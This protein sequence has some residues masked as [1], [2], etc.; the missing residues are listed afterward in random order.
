MTAVEDLI[1]KQSH[2]RTEEAVT[3]EKD[4]QQ[5]E[6]APLS[7]QVQQEINAM[8][9]CRQAKMGLRSISGLHFAIVLEMD[10]G[11]HWSHDSRKDQ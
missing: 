8:I 7:P 11:H 6:D 1:K 5:A 10:D 2:K 4:V 3:R 9:D